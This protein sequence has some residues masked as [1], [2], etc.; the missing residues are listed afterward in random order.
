MQKARFALN[1][2]VAAHCRLALLYWSK[3]ALK[4]AVGPI[5]VRQKEVKV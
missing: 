5:V 3:S 2:T 4:Q 1:L